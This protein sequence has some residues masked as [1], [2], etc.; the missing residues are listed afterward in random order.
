MSSSTTIA[1]IAT[2]LTAG[3]GVASVLYAIRADFRAEH[4]LANV[5]ANSGQELYDLRQARTALTK[6]PPDPAELQKAADIVRTLARASNLSKREK[7]AVLETLSRGSDTSVATYVISLVDE[8]ARTP[9]TGTD[10][11][12]TRRLDGSSKRQQPHRLASTPSD[13][14]YLRTCPTAAIDHLATGSHR[15]ANAVPATCPMGVSLGVLR[16]YSRSGQHARPP[17]A[18]LVNRIPAL[19]PKL[20]VHRHTVPHPCQN[21]PALTVIGGHSRDVRERSDLGPGRYQRCAN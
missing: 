16:G 8:A 6:K 3:I 4:D 2:S 18:V 13:P 10:D 1:I 21:A 19:I 14:S 7:R 17:A 11:D 20:I 12:A 15:G 9:G 5:I